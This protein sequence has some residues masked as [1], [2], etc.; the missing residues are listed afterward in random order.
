MGR[1]GS[2]AAINETRVVKGSYM[3][4]EG[5]PLQCVCNI[6]NAEVN[7]H[8]RKVACGV[9]H[10]QLL[11]LRVTVNAGDGASCLTYPKVDET[12]TSRLNTS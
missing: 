5:P 6:T 11:R 9:T 10:R 8:K 1:E 3:G 7:I 4:E 2:S 12:N